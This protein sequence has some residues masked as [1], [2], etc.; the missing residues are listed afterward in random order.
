MLC[1]HHLGPVPPELPLP[2]QFSTL[3]YCSRLQA[4]WRPIPTSCLTLGI[5]GNGNTGTFSEPQITCPQD[6]VTVDEDKNR[7]ALESLPTS[8]KCDLRSVT[9]LGG[10][11]SWFWYAER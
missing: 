5:P 1:S 11:I 9:T 4:G 3:Y 2:F 6:R 7:P 8:I 10:L